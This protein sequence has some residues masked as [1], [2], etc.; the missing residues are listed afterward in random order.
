MALLK[1][2]ILL[3]VAGCAA[4]RAQSLV[5]LNRAIED[6]NQGR[7]LPAA[8]GFFEVAEKG[9]SKEQRATAG[10]HLAQ[11][12]RK[13][14]YPFAAFSE[15]AQVLN[16]GP[17]HPFYGKAL[18]A[19]AA[20]TEELSDEVIGPNLLAK[21]DKA[22][23]AKL[24]PEARSRYAAAVALLDYRAGKYDEAEE[25]IR[26]VR[27]ATPGYAQARYLEG[28]L[29]QRK[30]PEQAVRTF[31]AVL[32]MPGESAGLKEL[33]HLALG[34]TLY[35]LKRYQEAAAEYARLPRFSRHWDEGLFE[36][37]Y[38]D[39]QSGDAGAALG[40]LHGLHSPH[41]SDE[42][43]PES[44]NLAAIIYDQVCLY[45]QVREALARFEREYV[46]M[47]DR[48]KT[49]ASANVPV[50]DFV[51]TLDAGDPRLPV[52]VRKHLA[53]NERVSSML[54]Y[55]G[56]L[57]REHQR[58]RGDQ[59]LSRTALGKDLAEALARQRQ[60]VTQVA[61]KFVQGRLAD[62]QHL[63]EVLDG[64][65]EI[66]GFETTKGEKEMIEARYDVKAA[67]DAQPLFRPEMP[68]TGHEY[69]PF[70]GEYW[71]DE[72]GYYRYTLKDA[73]PKKKEQE[74]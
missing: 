19:V 39:L 30:D 3:W 58:L 68:Q 13:L 24:S 23:V 17:A 70:D 72:I 46:P 60:L 11:T 44:H 63:I 1:R 64:E 73:C 8:L 45:P 35:G 6:L 15:Y 48:L 27:P 5:V 2:A 14:G 71:P 43:A 74:R 21:A 10:F 16:A 34:R 26:W 32:E 59:E 52:P 36:G 20:L 56:R 12:V 37:A 41:L 4:A 62:L 49:V 57:D 55:L 53:K 28:L 42:F 18:E 69:W 61:G 66:I 7:N 47:K 50:E 22:E 54:D 29:Q 9:T 25:L 31:R 38:A 51:R 67:L 33:A 40:K 65:K